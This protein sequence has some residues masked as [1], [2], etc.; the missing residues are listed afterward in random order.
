VPKLD[1]FVVKSRCRIG[2]TMPK[3]T[4]M[5]ENSV[6]TKQLYEPGTRIVFQVLPAFM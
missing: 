2:V 5:R 4:L 6:S 1:H 3:K